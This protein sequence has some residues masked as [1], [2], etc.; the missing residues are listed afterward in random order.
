MSTALITTLVGGVLNIWL[1]SNYQLLATGTARLISIIVELGE[2]R[3][4]A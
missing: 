2:D 1:M 3:A 4:G